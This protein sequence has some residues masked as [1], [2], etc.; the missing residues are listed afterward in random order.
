MSSIRRNSGIRIEAKKALR[1]KAK[2]KKRRG[3]RR[4]IHSRIRDMDSMP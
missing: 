3:T 4:F 1:K 2:K